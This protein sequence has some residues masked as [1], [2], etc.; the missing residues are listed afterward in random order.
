MMKNVV[1]LILFLTVYLIQQLSAQGVPRFWDDVQ[2][3]KKYDKIYTPPAHPIL[4]IGS[5][6]IRKWNDLER[7][8]AEYFAL[9]RGIGGAVINDVIYYANYVVF[10]YYPRQIVIYVGDNDLGNEETTADSIFVQSKRLIRVIRTKLPDI[11]IVYLSI[12]PSPSR[13]N[14]MNKA[15]AANSLVCNYIQLE[16]NMTFIDVF[17]KM[18]NAEG[19]PNP[20]LFENDMLHMNQ[21]GYKIWHKAIKP[22]LIKR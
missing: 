15:F 14:F 3:I 1:I 22:L 16:K 2:V 5:S 8:F 4:F 19:K 20:D 21:K 11:P 12:K 17:H 18:L 13:E 9:N 10:P 6:S 7:T